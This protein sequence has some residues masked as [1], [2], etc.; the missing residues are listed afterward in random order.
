MEA[1][2]ICPAAPLPVPIAPAPGA[3]PPSLVAGDPLSAALFSTYTREQLKGLCKEHG[4]ST[5][6]VKALLCSRLLQKTD[7][8][9]LVDALDR[10]RGTELL[11][12]G[13]YPACPFGLVEGE[14]TVLVPPPAP[15][16]STGWRW[17]R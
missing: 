9:A 13:I 14:L 6:G 17:W 12:G 7:A 2:P 11:G 1:V 10:L 16:G 4:L 3:S 5:N 8:P 15:V